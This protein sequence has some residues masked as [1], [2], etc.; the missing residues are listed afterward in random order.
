M[1]RVLVT[2]A[3]GFLGGAL[4]RRLREAGRTDVVAPP[5]AELDLLSADA[6]ARLA[7]LGKIDTVVHCAASR[8]RASPAPERFV[9]ET[10]INVDATAGLYDWARRSGVRAIVHLSTLSVLRPLEDPRRL[11]DERSPLVGPPFSPAGPPAHPYALTKRW[12]EELALALRPSFAAVA[13]VRP[14]MAYGRDQSPG[15]GMGRLVGAVRAGGAHVL[16]GETGHRYAP[17]FVDD[18]VHV[19]ERLTL[20]PRNIIV[21]VGGPT[22]ISERH[23]VG[24]LAELFGTSIAFESTSQKPLSFAPSTELVDTLF[25]G[26]IVTRWAEG[27]R[28]AF[29]S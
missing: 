5:R 14:G 11:L 23:L 2:G 6:P 12:A 18:V 7:L 3:A 25:P 27:S 17:V 22:P 16:A 19:L 9:E 8:G 13:I 28:R 15:S 26:R 21:N 20:D 4:V 10:A 1:Q 24:D 29:G